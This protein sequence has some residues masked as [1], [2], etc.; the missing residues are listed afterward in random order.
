M[1]QSAVERNTIRSLQSDPPMKPRKEEHVGPRLKN[2]RLAAKLSQ[3]Q[4][5]DA[6]GYSRALVS[7]VE[8]EETEPDFK[9]VRRWVEACHSSMAEFLGVAIP[10]D[11]TKE[12]I[13]DVR[14]LLALKKHPYVCD[15]IRRLLQAFEV[16]MHAMNKTDIQEERYK[17]MRR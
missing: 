11:M 10:K 4:L 3:Q 17:G 16:F 6:I 2:L 8:N 1:A 12:D 7:M 9:L 15:Q 14:R 5:A 13:E